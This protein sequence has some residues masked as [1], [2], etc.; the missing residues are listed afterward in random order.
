MVKGHWC[1]KSMTS[2]FARAKGPCLK[3]LDSLAP[4]IDA[5]K[6]MDNTVK[7]TKENL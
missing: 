3:N 1:L 5:Q 2:G 7:D 6:C 4:R